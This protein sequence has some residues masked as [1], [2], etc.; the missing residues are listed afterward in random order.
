MSAPFMLGLLPEG[1]AFY[2][3]PANSLADQKE[4]AI[5]WLLRR[6]DLISVHGVVN[7]TITDITAA[8]CRMWI[9]KADLSDYR[10]ESDFPEVVRN[11]EPALVSEVLSDRAENERGDRQ[12][13][14]DYRAGA[15]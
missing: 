11:H 14:A 12:L 8:Y 6:D 3:N 10:T 13:S 9:N 4:E 15:L 2:T 1:E 7:G 5:E